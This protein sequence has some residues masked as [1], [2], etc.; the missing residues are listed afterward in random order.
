MKITPR[1]VE[2][3]WGYELLW[4]ETAQYV[5]KILHVNAGESL[6]LQYHEIKD[7]TIHLLTGRMRFTV[8][9]AGDR[10]EE[11]ALDAGQSYRVRPG[12]IHR[13][14]ALTDCD[15]LEASTAHLDDV[16]RLEDRYGRAP[17]GDG[18]DQA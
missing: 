7:E 8:G 4:A 15:I 17:E 5:G 2:K 14:E 6:S 16:V 10:L 1:R 13:M 12:T 3:P 9:T 18:A 11:V